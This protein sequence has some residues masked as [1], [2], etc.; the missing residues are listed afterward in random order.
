MISLSLADRTITTELP[1]FIIGI[2]NCTPDSFYEQSRCGDKPLADGIQMARSLISEG[3]DII[4]VGG[5]S[6]RPGSSYIS[7]EEEIRRVVP[8]VESIRKESAIPISV[9]TRKKIVMEAAYNA[10]ADIVNDISALEDD[11]DLGTFASLH[12]LSVI[13][14]HKRGK[15]DIMQKDT[16]YTDV[17]AEVDSYLRER[18]LYAEQ[19]G[20]SAEKIIV[21]PGIGFGKSLDA[22]K[23]LITQCGKLCGGKYKVLMA[24]SR[25]TCIGEI[26]GRAV[27]GRLYGT[28][29][30]DMIAVQN[31]ASLLR[32]HD[33]AACRDTMKIL[34]S[35]G[36]TG[37]YIR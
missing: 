13:L 15:P 28:L 20:I 32:V 17:F 30:A 34:S 8:I 21:D 35:L 33:V 19:L 18:A 14:M 24:L 9:D 16:A 36:G 1:A 6:S 27:D 31:G 10:G 25:K 29:A 2:V 3:A 7:E 11:P 26:T 22:N 4:D 23:V 37:E 12:K 5:E